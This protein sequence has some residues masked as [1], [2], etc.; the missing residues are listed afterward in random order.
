MILYN[1]DNLHRFT[2]SLSVLL[3]KRRER[4]TQGKLGRLLTA[5][6]S[7]LMK[8]EDK[9]YVS[10]T[11]VPGREIVIISI[12]KES[13]AKNKS[14]FCP[15]ITR[16]IVTFV[17]KKKNHGEIVILKCYACAFWLCKRDLILLPV[18]VSFCNYNTS[19]ASLLTT[20]NLENP[21]CRQG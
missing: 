19:S 20:C 12:F 21:P 6:S 14:V 4:Q 18:D 15:S 10:L 5:Q 2:P 9:C 1:Y 8:I 3:G 13:K 16:I 11:V 7:F 17:A